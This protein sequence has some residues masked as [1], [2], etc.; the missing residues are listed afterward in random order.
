[1]GTS[2]FADPAEDLTAI[3]MSQVMWPPPVPPP[4]VVGFVDAVTT[5]S[6]EG[7][8]RGSG[9]ACGGPTGPAGPGTVGPVRRAAG[10]IA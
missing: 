8:I 9:A 7:R 1:M 5:P 2:W 10:G 4:L 6:A 3:M